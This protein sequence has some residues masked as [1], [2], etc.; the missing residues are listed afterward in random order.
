M[1][2]KKKIALGFLISA[3]IIAILAAFEYINFI[4]IKKEIRNLELTDTIRS[5]SLQLRRHEKNFFLYGMPKAVE[6]S[7]AIHKY[8]N[9]L[10]AIL[11]NNLTIDKT[12]KLSYLKKRIK[13]YGGR[14]NK[15]ESSVK[16]LTDE[17]EKI[18]DSYA[19]YHKFFPLIE[20]TFLERPH[21]AAEFLE[22][23]FLLPPNHRLVMGP[24]ELYSDIQI[25]RKDG[26]DIINISKDLDKVARENTEGVIHMSQIAILIF[27]PLFL[28]VGIGMLFVISNNVVN[29]LRL[30]IDFVEK[31]G[32][33]DYSH[34]PVSSQKAGSPKNLRIFWGEGDE[35]GVLIREFN[36]MENQLSQREEEL[37]RKNKELLQSKKLAAIGTLASGVAHELNNPLNNIY[38]SAQVLEREAKDECSPMIKETLDDIIGQTLRVK[39]IVG[40]LLEFA[41]GKEPQSREFELNELLMGAYKLVSTTTNTEGINFVMDTDPA[42]VIINADNEQME[43]VFINLFTN[44]VDAMSGKGSLDVKVMKEADS[45]TIKVSDTGRGMPADAVEKI[46]E[47]FY[48]TKDKGTGLGLAIVFNIIKKHGG[49]ISVES[50]EGRGTIFTITLP[51]ERQP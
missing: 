11:D 42:G 2:L 10:N 1:S 14:F 43:R 51:E 15:I 36:D 5:K 8:L 38:I 26:E 33:G 29:R 7:E 40:D 27:F 21:Q 25:L 19:R 12:G 3:F 24:R 31:T 32:K 41:R 9:E 39:R 23:V 48:T 28:V 4:E 30:L 45:V 49:D 17:F 16:D 44:A 35:V 46:F 22:K 34:I 6:E 20:S 47:P 13:E 37:D 18:K 50:G